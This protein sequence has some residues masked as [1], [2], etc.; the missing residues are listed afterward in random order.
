M[1]FMYLDGIAVPLSKIALG[2]TYFGTTI[3]KK[4]TEALLDA[5]A[6]ANGTTIDTARGYGDGS[7]ERVIGSW[8][9]ETGMRTHMVLVTKGLHNNADGSSRFSHRNLAHDIET[10]QEALGCESFDIWFFHRDNPSIPVGEI[11]EMIS[12]YVQSGI[13]K[14][15]G[16]SN[17]STERIE[18]ANKYADDH[19]LP[20]IGISEIQWSLARSTPK[21]WDDLSLVC[22]DDESLEWYRNSGMPVFAFSAQ[23]KGF[24]SKAIAHGIEGLSEKSRLRF[25]NPENARKIERVRVLSEMTQLSPAAIAIGYLTSGKPESVAIVGCSSVAQLYDTLSGAD[26]HLSPSQISFLETGGY[27]AT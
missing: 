12:P 11:I 23:S 20:C 8:M 10:S 13:I 26:V 14:T 24:F 2:S 4:T 7:S 18:E 16:A 19:D 21:S 17:W 3:D 22:M 5:F 9:R 15:L 27:D 6:G 1:R 25:L